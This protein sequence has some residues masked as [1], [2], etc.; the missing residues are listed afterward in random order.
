M[1]LEQTLKSTKKEVDK[2]L[3][4]TNYVIG[5]WHQDLQPDEVD[6]EVSSQK[7]KGGK[8]TPKTEKVINKMR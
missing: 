1:S 2:Q 8:K 6:Q 4:Q 3:P 5:L 7:G